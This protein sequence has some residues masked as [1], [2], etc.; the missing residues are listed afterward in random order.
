[1]QTSGEPVEA[2]NC[3]EP[4]R[5]FQS[6]PL[7][8]SG[9]AALASH[10]VM[11][12]G[13]PMQP[14]KTGSR[15]LRL[16]WR[17]QSAG[18]RRRKSKEMLA[19]TVMRLA[20]RGGSADRAR[21]TRV[22]PLT[23]GDASKA[24]KVVDKAA[25]TTTATGT[26]PSPTLSTPANTEPDYSSEEEGEPPPLT[27]DQQLTQQLR[28]SMAM[29]KV[30]VDTVD[31]RLTYEFGGYEA[32]RRRKRSGELAELVEHALEGTGTEDA[33]TDRQ[34]LPPS[35]APVTSVESMLTWQY[36]LRSSSASSVRD[37]PL[38]FAA[39]RSAASYEL[40]TRTLLMPAPPQPLTHPLLG[41]PRTR[42]PSGGVVVGMPQ[43]QAPLLKSAPQR[44]RCGQI[45]AV[46]EPEHPFSDLSSS[47]DESCDAG[48]G[49]SPTPLTPCAR[50]GRSPVPRRGPALYR[51]SRASS[52]SPPRT[53][54]QSHDEA[55][56]VA[57]AVAAGGSVRLGA[58]G[59][60]DSVSVCWP[61]LASS[62]GTLAVSAIATPRAHRAP[63]CAL[64]RACPDSGL[65]IGR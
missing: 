26:V 51:T 45:R 8:A 43:Q 4:P 64:I 46:S 7:T 49:R 55:A 18:K 25:A 11:P 23:Y 63:L 40:G 56:S 58:G 35:G 20:R 10:G 19:N 33:I 54:K 38:G 53:P 2:R 30:A 52:L 9:A 1:M 16:P 59:E 3:A 47:E 5:C 60:G 17:T 42:T 36:R 41:T 39:G 29:P 14:R 21:S 50:T 28:R 32:A 34:S 6:T 12:I 57:A 15:T 22:L 24:A 65:V 48:V 27:I 61:M 62:F 31:H 44:S 37:I 13:H